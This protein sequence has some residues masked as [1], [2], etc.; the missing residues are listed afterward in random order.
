MFNNET[1]AKVEYL[2]QMINL[3]DLM[4]KLRDSL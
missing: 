1:L 2:E 4:G 3:L